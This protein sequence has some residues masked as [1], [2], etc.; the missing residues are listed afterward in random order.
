[1][2]I[3]VLLMRIDVHQTATSGISGTSVAL[4]SIFYSD[5]SARL[6]VYDRKL[7]FLESIFL[8]CCTHI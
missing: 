6:G 8:M 1:M 7:I 2:L 4:H 5:R 3:D